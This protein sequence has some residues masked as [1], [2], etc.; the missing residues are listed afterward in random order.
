MDCFPGSVRRKIAQHGYD[1]LAASIE[2]LH[3]KMLKHRQPTVYVNSVQSEEA[4]TIGHVLVLWQSHL[5]RAERLMVSCG[6]AID[7]NDPY[8]LAVLIRAF[9][10]ST[11]VVCSIRAKLLD[12]I[13]GRQTYEA[14]DAILTATLV[15]SRNPCLEG[16]PQAINILSHIKAAD[17]YIDAYLPMTERSP[18]GTMYGALSEYA[19]PNMPSNAVAFWIEEPGVYRFQHKAKITEKHIIF[20][21]MLNTSALAF[22]AVSSS[23]DAWLKSGGL[24]PA[25]A[26]VT[27]L[28]G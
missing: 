16:T 14:F 25:T 12:W 1:G 15:G 2:R 5:H 4:V 13:A 27:P 20:L 19:H 6:S 17:A 28:K 11:A 22:E 9:V 23:Y 3:T 24:E 26:T 7:N 8:G 10:E 18:L 21:G